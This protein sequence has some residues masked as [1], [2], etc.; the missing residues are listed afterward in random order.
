MYLMC[1][2]GVDVTFVTPKAC[3]VV[4]TSSNGNSKTFI[5]ICSNENIGTPSSTKQGGGLNWQVPYVLAPPRL[6]Y[7]KKHEKCNVYDVVFHPQSIGEFYNTVAES[8]LKSCRLAEIST[9]YTINN[10]GFVL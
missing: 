8:V 10:L 2:T 4:K 6:D 1:P 9:R 5:N 3:F 7:D